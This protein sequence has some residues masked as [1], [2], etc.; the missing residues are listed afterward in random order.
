MARERKGFTKRT[1]KEKTPYRLFVIA[2]EG[3]AT[4]KIYFDA[5]SQMLAGEPNKTALIKIE[6]LER[7]ANLPEEKA[8]NAKGSS[9]HLNVIKQLDAYKK[10]YRLV[11]NDELWLVIDRDYQNNPIGNIEEVA[12]RCKQKGYFLGITCPNFELWLLL[13]LKNLSEYSTE[14]Q[15]S[16]VKPDKKVNEKRN[17]LTKELAYILEGYDKSNYKIELILPHYPL[18]VEQA[19]QLDTNPQERWGEGRLFSRLYVL[20]EHIFNDVV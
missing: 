13:H 4:E 3:E 5:L 1:S 2:S 9:G 20:F 12:R 16:F 11:E 17:A 8:N 7:G 6:F 15:E 19:R 14:Q 18:A 10:E